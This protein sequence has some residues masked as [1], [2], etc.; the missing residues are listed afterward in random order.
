MG[1]GSQGNL[2]SI[3]GLFCL[4]A[5]QCEMSEAIAACGLLT[6]RP[7]RHVT[8]NLGTARGLDGYFQGFYFNPWWGEGF[9]SLRTMYLAWFSLF[10][11]SWGLVDLIKGEN[12]FST[13]SGTFSAMNSFSLSLSFLGLKLHI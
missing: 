8:G 5:I 1:F 2:A 7:Y 6:S 4:P 10:L 3:S 12:I 9:S 11:S 13:K